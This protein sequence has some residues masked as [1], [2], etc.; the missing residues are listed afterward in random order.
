MNSVVEAA[1]VVIYGKACSSRT[2]MRVI[3][4][5]EEEIEYAILF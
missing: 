5:A 4:R 2:E 3:I 1:L